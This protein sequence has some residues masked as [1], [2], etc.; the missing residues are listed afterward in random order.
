MVEVR[1]L[2]DAAPDLLG[3]RGGGGRHLGD[4][5]AR[6]GQPG[7][8]HPGPPGQPPVHRQGHGDVRV[9]RRGPVADPPGQLP[10]ARQRAGRAP[11]A[12]RAA[13]IMSSS[14]NQASSSAARQ[15]IC[16]T[17]RIGPLT[18]RASGYHG[19][20][21]PASPPS[22]RSRAACCPPETTGVSRGPPHQDRRTHR[23]GS[24]S[25]GPSSARQPTAT[26]A[27]P[28]TVHA[29]ASASGAG[30]LT[31]ACAAAIAHARASGAAT[32]VG[33]GAAAPGPSISLPIRHGP[34]SEAR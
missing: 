14:P 23:S 13:V 34:G 10:R 25:A 5:G 2:V 19:G 20:T 18:G 1:A 28:R 6:T 30:T 21:G 11:R 26:S 27:Q 9:A 24:R 29:A 3:Q 16:L 33:P 31:A 22:W 7:Q 8:A 4:R 17:P 32:C 12:A 15:A